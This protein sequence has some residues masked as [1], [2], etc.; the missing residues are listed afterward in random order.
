MYVFEFGDGRFSHLVLSLFAFLFS[1]F[2]IFLF[3]SFLTSYITYPSILNHMTND[4][5]N[6]QQSFLPT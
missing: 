5:E 1:V 3:T 2:H 4:D 6:S